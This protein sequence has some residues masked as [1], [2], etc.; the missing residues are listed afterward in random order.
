MIMMVELESVLENLCNLIYSAGHGI[1]ILVNS[2]KSFMSTMK[3]DAMLNFL[4]SHVLSC[5]GLTQIPDVDG[6]R[7]QY[8][9]TE[10]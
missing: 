9:G 4:R 1:P 10:P 8:H 3:E 7:N 5:A 2:D 6:G